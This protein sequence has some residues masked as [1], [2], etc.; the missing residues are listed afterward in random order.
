MADEKLNIYQRM[1]AVMRDVAYIRKDGRMA[2]SGGNYTFV[3][4]DAV[5][6]KVRPALL[7][8]GIVVTS[9]AIEHECNGNR[10]EMTCAV[11]FTSTDDPS[12]YIIVNGVGYGIDKQDKGP[13]KAMSYA[14]KYAILKALALET[15]DDPE[16]DAI[17]YDATPQ[18]T[19]Q[20]LAADAK[21]RAMDG[22][23]RAQSDTGTSWDA[24]KKH[25][26]RATADMDATEIDALAEWVREHAPKPADVGDINAADNTDTARLL[27]EIAGLRAKL[28]ALSHDGDYV[29][30]LRQATGIREIADAGAVG[31]MSIGDLTRVRDEL[32]KHA[33]KGAAA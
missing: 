30:L 14:T 10:T 26:G 16:N 5:M 31:N 3:S 11:R 18:P 19:P 24:I 20:Q 17:D 25:A 7:R 32:A 2:H 28:P 27:V 13:G 1:H 33:A 21:Q 23:K 12:D 6:A 4:H 22:L 15:G 29:Q 8:H 9:S